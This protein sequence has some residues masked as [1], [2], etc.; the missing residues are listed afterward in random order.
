MSSLLLTMARKMGV[1]T[2]R[3]GDSSRELEL[4]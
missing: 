1:E 4:G 3:F 2:E